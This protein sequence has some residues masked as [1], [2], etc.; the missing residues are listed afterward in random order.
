MS[1]AG[2]PRDVTLSVPSNSYWPLLGQVVQSAWNGV[3]LNTTL[4]VID[5]TVFGGTM[6]KAQHDVF[7]WD[8]TQIVPV[9]WAGYNLL[10]NP[11]GAVSNRNGGWR[12]TPLLHNLYS[13]IAEPNPKKLGQKIAEMDKIILQNAVMQANYYPTSICAYSKR[14]KGFLPPTGKAVDLSRA[15]LS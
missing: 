5:A 12:D 8:L 15:T 11:A 4:K 3:G 9:P 1:A 2:G 13:S 14:L 6:N 7:F 10:F